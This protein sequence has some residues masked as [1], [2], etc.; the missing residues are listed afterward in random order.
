M[1]L[2]QVNLATIANGETV[3]SEINK[4]G[5]DQLAIEVPSGDHAAAVTIQILSGD[6]TTFIDAVTLADTS[7]QVKPLSVAELAVVATATRIKLKLGSGVT[8]DKSY[9]VHMSN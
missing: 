8:G 2:Q 1:K 9:Y 4:E 7:N 3:S 6:G 5:Y